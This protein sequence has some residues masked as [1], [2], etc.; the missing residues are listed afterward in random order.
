MSD[1]IKE[2]ATYISNLKKTEADFKEA[3]V[4]SIENNYC[5]LTQDEK[6]KINLKL[7]KN[8]II[9]RIQNARKEARKA[10]NAYQNSLQEKLEAFGSDLN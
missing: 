1:E 8:D 2:F 10:K 5:P 3:V 9:I 7:K 4:A 6:A